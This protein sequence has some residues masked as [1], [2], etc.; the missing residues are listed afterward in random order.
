MIDTPIETLPA[1]WLDAYAINETA[2]PFVP[3]R[4][5]R[6]W[7]DHFTARQPYRCLPLSMAN[8]TGWEL[9]CPF[10]VDIEWNGGADVEDIMITSPENN[11]HVQSLAQSHFR[12]GIVTFH[13]GYLFRTPPGWAVTCAGPPNWPKDGIY[14]YSGLIE[15]DWLP[16]P[17]TMNWQ[18]TRPG[19]VR[20]EK[21]DPF[22][23]INLCEHRRLEDVQPKVKALKANGA[24]NAEYQA[25]TESRGDFI[26]KLNLGEKAALSQGWQRHYM[27]GEKVSGSA[28]EAEH[29]TKRRM[30]KPIDLRGGAVL[31]S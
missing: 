6:A 20:F 1:P 14:A 15:T 10:A 30:K 31:K 24:L 4:P 8:S 28:V 18:M 5:D 29:N 11:V 12:A 22:C 26:L 2:P 16:Y 7:M 13:T 3:A 27:H 25:W 19:K 21:G 23:F 17:F 9:T